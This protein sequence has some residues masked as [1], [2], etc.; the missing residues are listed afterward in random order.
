MS[1]RIPR[2][3]RTFLILAAVALSAS[4]LAAH[5]LFLKMATYFLPPQTP[6]K[7]LLLNGTFTKS[8]G[9]VARNRIAD[10][11]LVTPAG[12]TP[13]MPWEAGTFPREAMPDTPR[14]AMPRTTEPHGPGNRWTRAARITPGWGNRS[15][16]CS[17]R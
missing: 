2:G 15:W 9:T 11:S 5:D 17:R 6:V 1:T 7:V 16:R 3:A 8:E 12:R 10:L 14:R 4:S 13:A